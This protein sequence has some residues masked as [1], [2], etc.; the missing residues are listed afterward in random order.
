MDPAT[1]DDHATVTNESADLHVATPVLLDSAQIIS[2]HLVFECTSEAIVISTKDW[3]ILWR[4]PVDNRRGYSAQRPTATRAC[5]A[6]ALAAALAGKAA[7]VDTP[8]V[9]CCKIT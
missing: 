7:Q 1:S 5:L 9:K 6:E 3:K 4:G 2:R 8:A